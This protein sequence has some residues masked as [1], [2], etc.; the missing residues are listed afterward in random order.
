MTFGVGFYTTTSYEQAER[1]ARI[2]MRRENKSVGYVSVYAFDLD[3]AENDCIIKRFESADKEWLTFVVANRRGKSAND[4]A[5]MHIGPVADDNV[6]QSKCLGKGDESR[7]TLRVWKRWTIYIPS[8]L[9]F[10]SAEQTTLNPSPFPR[11]RKR[12]SAF[13]TAS[14]SGAK[15][16]AGCWPIPKAG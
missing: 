3:E 15:N 8:P 9:P 16:S 13:S 6:Y 2:K 10:S 5:D 14:Q 11:S 12:Y 4:G 7:L 1:W